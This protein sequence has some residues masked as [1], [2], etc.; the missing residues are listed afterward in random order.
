MTHRFQSTPPS[1]GGDIRLSSCFPLSSQFQST[2][3]ARGAT[4]AAS[5]SS[6][7]ACNFNPRPP[8]GG[9]PRQLEAVCKRC[10]ISIHA[11]REGG[12]GTT[13]PGQRNIRISIHAPR[14][15]GDH[16]LR[17]AML[18]RGHF[19]PRPPRG[20]RRPTVSNAPPPMPLQSTPPARGATVDRNRRMYHI[21]ISIHA[22]REGGDDTRTGTTRPTVKISI[23][24]PREGGDRACMARTGRPRKI[25]IH[26]PRE[27]GDAGR[28]CCPGCQLYFNPRP[29]RGGRQ[30]RCTVLPADL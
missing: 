25:S 29:P 12:D 11:P 26:A 13:P 28:K 24:A 2:P 1:R 8:R 20:G 7:P 5:M 9:R 10:H 19:N 27:G 4:A 22:P 21:R 23:H 18:A 15:G 17:I 30:Q 16:I 3:P 14:E 6:D